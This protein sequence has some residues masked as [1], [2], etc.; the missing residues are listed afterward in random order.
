MAFPPRKQAPPTQ[1]AQ[2]PEMGGLLVEEIPDEGAHVNYYDL[3][4]FDID[5][6]NVLM[7]DTDGEHRGMPVFKVGFHILLLLAL[8]SLL[9]IFRHCHRHWWIGD[10]AVPP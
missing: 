1:V 5:P 10:N 9:S 2:Y 6:Q 4:H 8:L 7:F 3:V